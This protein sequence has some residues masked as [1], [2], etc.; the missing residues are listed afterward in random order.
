[1][2]YFA[3][4]LL[5]L[6]PCFWQDHIQAGDLGSHTY[7]VWLVQLIGAGQA[8]SLFVMPVFTNVLFDWWSSFCIAK[9]GFLWGE[10]FAV[11]TV[12]LTFYW[13]AWTWI[14]TVTG[15]Q[16]WAITALLAMFTYGWVFFMGFMNFYWSMGLCLFALAAAESANVWLRRLWWLL[17]IPAGMAHMLP[18]GWAAALW[19]YSLV[20]ARCN[21]RWRAILLTASL[22]AVIC[23]SFAIRQRYSTEWAPDQ[24]LGMLGV[25]QLMLA[26][27]LYLIFAVVVL[28]V[29]ALSLAWAL[30]SR[31]LSTLPMHYLALSAIGVFL[32]PW[33][34]RLP[35]FSGP[36]S[37]IT[38][39]MSL[40]CAVFVCALAVMAS[41]PK[42]ILGITTPFAL[43]YFGLLYSEAAP[44]NEYENAL[45][46]AVRELPTKSRVCAPNPAGATR[47]FFLNHIVDRAC[48]GHCYSY[49]NYEAA[50]TQFR[51]RAYG[52]NDIVAHDNQTSVELQSANHTV[53][54]DEAPIYYLKWIPEQKRFETRVLKAGDKF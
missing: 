48:I 21:D 23:L 43:A 13:G 6:I 38:Q 42:V 41:K 8:P 29:G 54:A 28:A 4:S 3:L 32:I 1:M 47:V 15:K 12:V 36:L 40:S 39:R 34:I 19:L 31:L 27:P 10:R 17:L 49:A 14:R 37:F 46:K 52:P 44:L 16:P 30:D 26:T 5:L 35:G 20:H 9:A 24:I 50:T 25:D 22:A 18:V 45:Y 33:V 11:S 7:N 51:V 2:K 53:T